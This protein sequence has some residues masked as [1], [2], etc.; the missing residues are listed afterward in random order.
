MDRKL[1]YSA[2]GKEEIINQ[3]KKN[4]SYEVG[5]S[6]KSLAYGLGIVI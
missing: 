4:L 5:R 6:A 3:T 1:Q 2:Q